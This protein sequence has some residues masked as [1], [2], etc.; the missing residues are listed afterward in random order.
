MQDRGIGCGGDRVLGDGDNRGGIVIR[1]LNKN[2]RKKR[3]FKNPNDEFHNGRQRFAFLVTVTLT[4]SI[5]RSALL[6]R[7]TSPPLPY[8]PTLSPPPALALI[9]SSPLR[10]YGADQQ[11]LAAAAICPRP[12]AS[13]P[14][15]PPPFTTLL[16]VLIEPFAAALICTRV[17][18]RPFVSL[19]PICM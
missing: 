19:V 12:A 5:Q 1:G 3:K 10:R 18:A 9:S 11:S 7:R 14:S 15:L 17:S 2:Q 8:L 6:Q 4:P 13:L 16:F